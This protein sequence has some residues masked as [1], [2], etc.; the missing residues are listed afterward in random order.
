MNLDEFVVKNP[1]YLVP[2]QAR[3]AMLREYLLRRQQGLPEDVAFQLVSTGHQYAAAWK[4]EDRWELAFRAAASLTILA[5]DSLRHDVMLLSL[6][7]RKKQVE[8][9]LDDLFD[10]STSM[11]DEQAKAAREYLKYSSEVDRIIDRINEF[12]RQAATRFAEQNALPRWDERRREI[13]QDLHAAY[14][15]KGP[16]YDLLCQQL[17]SA[18]ILLEQVE[19]SPHNLDPS[20]YAKMTQVVVLLTNQLQKFTEATKSEAIRTEVQDAL[21]KFMGIVEQ[22]VAPSYPSLWNQL[23]QEVVR[24]AGGGQ[25]IDQIIEE[26]LPRLTSAGVRD[27]PAPD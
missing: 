5:D 11:G 17:V 10:T 7:K 9:I 4:I 3:V 2:D 26:D 19:A 24:R 27:D 6:L 18:K 21:V 15:G 13:S 23:V 16:Q 14:H 22:V 25:V 12:A 8:G 1:G 20:D